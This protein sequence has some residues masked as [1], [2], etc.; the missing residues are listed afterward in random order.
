M[1]NFCSQVISRKKAGIS[2]GIPLDNEKYGILENNLKC[3]DEGKDNVSTEYFNF[4]ITFCKRE[5][6]DVL[7]RTLNDSII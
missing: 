4:I 3:I 7:L 6:F 5:D 2:F 1:T